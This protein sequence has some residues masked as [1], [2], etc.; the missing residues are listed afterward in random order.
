MKAKYEA[1]KMIQVALHTRLLIS[2]SQATQNVYT[3]D[4]QDVGNAM[5]N[6]STSTNIW[7]DEW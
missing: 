1:P 3:D 6:E 5:V 7:D 2:V 4:A